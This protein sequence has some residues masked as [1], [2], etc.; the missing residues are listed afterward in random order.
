MR[1]RCNNSLDPDNVQF[2]SKPFYEKYIEIASIDKEKNKKNLIESYNY[3][4]YYYI[5]QNDLV[6]GKSFYEK[7]IELDAT[8]EDALDKLKILN[9]K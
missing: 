4:A 6:Q 7:I 9:Q 2:L 3:L 5:Q 1:A 8:N